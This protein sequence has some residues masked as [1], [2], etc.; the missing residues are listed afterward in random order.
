[1]HHWHHSNE[2]DAVCLHEVANCG[3]GE[4]LVKWGIQIDLECRRC[5]APETTTHVLQCQADGA[6]EQWMTSTDKLW[7]W[8][9][10]LTTLPGLQDVII[11]N[12]SHWRED[13]PVHYPQGGH[14]WPHV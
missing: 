12:L 6:K 1:M 9:R 2:T 7:K 8:M 13:R 4:T 5:G 14:Q 11:T 3:V 10:K